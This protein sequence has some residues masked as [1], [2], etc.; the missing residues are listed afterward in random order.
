MESKTNYSIQVSSVSPS[1]L[2]KPS[3]FHHKKLNLMK[4]SDFFNSSQ[5]IN[6]FLSIPQIISKIDQKKKIMLTKTDIKMFFGLI[7]KIDVS[8]KRTFK[9]FQIISSSPHKIIIPFNESVKEKIEKFV[10]LLLTLAYYINFSSS[11]IAELYRVGISVSSIQT[12]IH[13]LIVKLYE[14]EHIN[15]CRFF[16]FVKYIY[17]INE[18]IDSINEVIGENLDK[19]LLRRVDKGIPAI[20]FLFFS[21]YPKVMTKEPQQVD[22]YINTFISFVREKLEYDINLI[23][24]VNTKTELLKLLTLLSNNNLTKETKKEIFI[25]LSKIYSF[26][27]KQIH[28]SFMFKQIKSSIININ[29]LKEDSYSSGIS[30]ISNQFELLKQIASYES[31]TLNKDPFYIN[32]GFLFNG[33]SSNGITVGTIKSLKKEFMIIFSFT[34]YGSD[35]DKSEIPIISFNDDKT[36]EPLIYLYIRNN[37]ELTLDVK[38]YKNKIIDDKISLNK[39]YHIIF[40]TEKE[41]TIFSTYKFNVFVNSNKKSDT[42]YFDEAS[43]V[44]MTIGYVDNSKNNSETFNGKIGT[45]LVYQNTLS[46]GSIK[47]ILE[48]KNLYFLIEEM[49]GKSSEEYYSFYSSKKNLRALDK[50]KNIQE[51]LSKLRLICLVSQRILWNISAFY[52][53]TRFRDNINYIENQYEIEY[54]FKVK[55]VARYNSTF[56][57]KNFDMIEQFMIY[58]GVNYITLCIEYF[59]NIIINMKSIQIAGQM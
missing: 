18:T 2:N 59:Y 48:L 23:Y 1:P 26:N 15:L 11:S 47:N 32:K 34:F 50:I 37:K 51:D 29:N 56:T 14:N 39:S 12:S 21:L 22:F 57:F 9:Y 49:Y 54:L 5:V 30:L 25:L 17:S 3:P 13:H 55:P 27:L 31:S 7:M 16:L 46:Q 53:K 20:M 41:G 4:I 52:N 8:V 38:K 58:E 42:M 24:C 36:K 44:K 28:F 43:N 19:T 10:L 35:S 45:I 40:S 6:H 33:N